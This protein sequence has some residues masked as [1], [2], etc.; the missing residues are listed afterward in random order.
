MDDMNIYELR[1]AE[2]LDERLSIIQCIDGSGPADQANYNGMI[3]MLRALGYDVVIRDGKHIV[4]DTKT[5][6]E[7]DEDNE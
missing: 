5:D 3:H 4:F 1:A 6:D 7:E 2:M